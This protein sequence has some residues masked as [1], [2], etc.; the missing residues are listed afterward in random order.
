[1][2]LEPLKTPCVAICKMDKGLGICIG[3]GRTMVEIGAWAAMSDVEREIG[4]KV[5]ENRLHALFIGDNTNRRNY[6]QEKND[7]S[8]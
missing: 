1:M 5:A 7:N 6:A 8:R 3:C 2:P 4:M